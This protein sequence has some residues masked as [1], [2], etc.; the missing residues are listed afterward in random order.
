MKYIIDQITDLKNGCQKTLNLLEK[1]DTQT[2]EKDYDTLLITTEKCLHNI[3]SLYL[4]HR[5]FLLFLFECLPPEP[6][7]EDFCK[8]EYASFS[9]CI[10]TLNRFEFPVYRITLPFLLPNKR[11]R[12]DYF[13]NALTKAVDSAVKDFCYENEIWPIKHATVI[14][15][16]SHSGRNYFVDNDNKESSVVTNAL[17]GRLIS[18]DRP[19]NCN[20][21]YYTKTNAECNKTEVYI[22]ESDHDVEV[23][24]EIKGKK[25]VTKPNFGVSQSK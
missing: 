10:E 14:F 8:T 15:A 17:N 21:I 4:K 16:S 12:H 5:E 2:R 19:N 6:K 7:I 23:Y 3:S 9:I 22:V 24:A 13:N 25:R 1:M 20:T 18:D 11:K